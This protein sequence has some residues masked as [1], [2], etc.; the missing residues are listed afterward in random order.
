[1][2]TFQDNVY[3][4]NASTNTPTVTETQAEPANRQKVAYPDAAYPTV[5]TLLNGKFQ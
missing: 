2:G 4:K 1:M 5:A 3:R